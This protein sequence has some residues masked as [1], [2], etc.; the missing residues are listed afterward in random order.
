M[1]FHLGHKVEIVHVLVDIVDNVL[2]Y[3]CND[4]RMHHEIMNLNI[5]SLA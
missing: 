2:G 1:V 5:K 3:W 4:L